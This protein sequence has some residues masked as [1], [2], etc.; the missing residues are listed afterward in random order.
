MRLEHVREAGR[1]R[2][3]TESRR[4]VFSWR[5]DSKPGVS[6]EG[7]FY[8]RKIAGGPDAKRASEDWREILS[9]KA[10]YNSLRA[11]MSR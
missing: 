7:K 6:C 2:K 4:G 8:S 3:P 11:K 10:G 1:K 5:G 9:V